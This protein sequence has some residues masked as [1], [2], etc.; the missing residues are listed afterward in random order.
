MTSVPFTPPATDRL[1]EVTLDGT[2]IFLPDGA[3]LAAALLQAG[4]LRFGETA[5]GSPRGPHCLMGTC[6]ACAMTIDD[7]A[8]QRSCRA[9]V[10]AGLILKTIP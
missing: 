9:T 8:Q 6:H 2:T 5:D 4:V 1:V 10:R 3:N 7:A